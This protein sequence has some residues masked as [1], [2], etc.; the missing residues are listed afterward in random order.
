MEREEIWLPY[1][2]DKIR[3]EIPLQNLLG[4]YYPKTIVAEVDENYILQQAMENPIGSLR[5]KEIVRCGQKVAI[6][7]SDL[8]RP[9]PSDKMLPF[10]IGELEAA[11]IPDEDVFIVFALGIHRPMSEEEMKKAISPQI[12]QRFRAINHDLNDVVTLG[13]TQRGTVVEIFRPLVE[14]DVRICL[15]NIEFHYFAG[16]SGGAKAI[17]PGCASRETIYANHRWLVSPE[18]SAMRIKGNPVR[19]DL[20]EGVAML[21]VD[22]ILN[23]IVDSQH[24]IVAAF[25]GDVIEAHRAGCQVVMER[26]AIDISQR[27]DI[28]IASPGGYP[29]DINLLQSNKALQSAKDFVRDKGIIILVAEC[30]E[31]FGNAVLEQWMKEIPTAE[32]TIQKIREKFVQGGHIAAAIAMIE[33]RASIY[34]VSSFE[35]ST[36][37]Q[38]RWRPFSTVQAAVDHAF[39]VLGKDAKV[40]VLPEATSIFA[41][42]SG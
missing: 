9:T 16:F 24:R 1:G 32:E 18:A 8:T 31:G 30:A 23:V 4:V 33:Q 15:G 36:V 37:R 10:V 34:C 25:A 13:V 22:F 17:L 21:G 19:E 41:K 14:A 29:K 26:G 20:E 11:G 7:T 27:G 39:E 6:V 2:K 3:I 42:V 5:L 35:D 40:I 12:Y 28:V 38:I